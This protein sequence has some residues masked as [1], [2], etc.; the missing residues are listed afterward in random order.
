MTEGRRWLERAIALAADDAGAPLAKVAHELGTLLMQQGELD[1]AL[2]LLERSMA[3]WRGLGDREQQSRDLN[4]LGIAHH[5]LGDLDT[6]RSLL[7]DG[8]A[9]AREIGGGFPLRAAL[10]NLGQVEAEAGN[11]DRATQLLQ[12]ALALDQIQDDLWGIAHNQGSLAQVSLRAG[13]AGEARDLLSATF[14]YVV[15]S[16]DAELLASTLETSACIAADLGEGR[17]AARLAGAAE[18]SGKRRYAGAATRR[19]PARAVPGSRPGDHRTRGVAR[20]A[21]RWPRAHPAAGSHAPRVTHVQYVTRP[22]THQPDT[23]HGGQRG[24]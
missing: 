21:G 14:G 9:I 6:A 10:T 2:R 15:S 16:S 12:E 22:V 13:R 8:V 17:R 20:R 11:F 18:P 4:N 1:T 5:H 24:R 3:I 19:G 7:E 23:A